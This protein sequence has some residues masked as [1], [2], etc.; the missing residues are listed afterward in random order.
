MMMLRHKELDRLIERMEALKRKRF[1]P[2]VEL[3]YIPSPAELG[4]GYIGAALDG[5]QRR[6]LE[7]APE[8]SRIAIAAS[9]QSGKSTVTAVFV[10][11][12]LMFLP[13]FTCLV[14]SRSLRQAAY[15]LDKVRDIVLSVIPRDAMQ[16]MNRLSMKL[17][18]GN[19]I[20]SIPC[21]QPDAGRGFSPDLILLDEAA[22]APEALFTAI[23]P[24]VAA[25][26]GAIHMISSPN[27][28]QGVFFEAFE[29][30]ASDVWETF[31]VTWKDCPRM[32][33]AQMDVERITL[34][35]LYWR[36]EFMAEFVQPLGAF[37]GNSGLLAFSDE[38]DQDLGSLE[39]SELEEVVHKKIGDVQPTVDDLR[40]AMDAADRVNRLLTEG[41]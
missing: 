28:R 31:R 6:Y 36:Q 18:N 23:T 17:P 27:G 14:A 9:R 32:T 3:D 2:L 33:Q 40:A 10:A 25:T 16:S 4:I 41:T 38:E 13:K 5:W 20:I 11:W 15:Y 1:N 35:D 12:C 7:R 21:A 39:L 24:S 37:F 26:H 8:C 34:G 29:G 22:F 19:E 30:R